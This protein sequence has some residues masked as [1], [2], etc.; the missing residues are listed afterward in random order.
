MEYCSIF[1]LMVEY[2]NRLLDS[3]TVNNVEGERNIPPTIQELREIAI[4][5]YKND[6]PEQEWTDRELRR[7]LCHHFN[8]DNC[9]LGEVA[10][11]RFER[12]LVRS[13]EFQDYINVRTTIA[14]QSMMVRMWIDSH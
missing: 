4:R 13:L 3:I 1:L 5:W 14:E 10:C 8:C 7:P 6:Y 12:K 2:L 9:P 11:D